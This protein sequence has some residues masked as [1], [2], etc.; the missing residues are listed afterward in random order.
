[1]I[2]DNGVNCT[3]P[4][5]CRGPALHCGETQ[6]RVWREEDW[7]WVTLLECVRAPD[8]LCSRRSRRQTD[9]GAR[10]ARDRSGS[11][12]RSRWR[13]RLENAAGAG[14]DGGVQEEGTSLIL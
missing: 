9:E 13:R 5:T 14:N 3:P 8:S 2:S 12:R 1:M 7:W 11:A 4:T 10:A 6:R